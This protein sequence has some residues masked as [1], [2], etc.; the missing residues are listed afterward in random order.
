MTFLEMQTRVGE[1]VGNRADITSTMIKASINETYKELAIPFRFHEQ[2]YEDATITTVDGTESYTVPTGAYAIVE[3]KDQT[4]H[5]VLEQVDQNA[6]DEMRDPDLE[7]PPE[8]FMNWAGKIYIWPVP[9]DVYDL[10]VRFKKLPA[11]M[12][13]DTDTPLLP[14]DW[15]PIICMLSASDLC[16]R[17]NMAE[18]GMRLKNEGLGRLSTRQEAHQVERR[19]MTGQ[20]VPQ[21]TKYPLSRTI[22]NWNDPF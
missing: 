6:Y 22:R 4:N 11:D 9:D 19:K 18:T 5:F 20:F 13:G 8:K 14:L 3:V 16:M 2:E 21:R 1:Y 15:H 12:T 17:F 10:L 7:G